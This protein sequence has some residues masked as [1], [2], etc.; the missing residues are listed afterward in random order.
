VARTPH[1]N[2]YL[3]DALVARIDALAQSTDR[4]RSKT[5]VWLARVGLTLDS[6]PVEW[7]VDEAGKQTPTKTPIGVSSCSN[8]K[9]ALFIAPAEMQ[10][11]VDNF[12][13]DNNFESFSEALRILMSAALHRIE[14]GSCAYCR[15]V[16]L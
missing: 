7:G 9:K 5:M 3:N 2:V 11:L 10:V 14:N 6:V 12:R 8:G 1:F 15:G 4:S 16:E 13:H